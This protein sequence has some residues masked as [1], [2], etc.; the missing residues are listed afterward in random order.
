MFG[1]IAWAPESPDLAY[2]VGWDHS[3]W[4]SA[5]GGKTWKHIA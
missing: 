2:A 4:R 5:D 3:V 1:P